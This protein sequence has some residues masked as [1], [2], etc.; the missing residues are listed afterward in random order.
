METPLTGAER[1]A[2]FRARLK[3][4]GLRRVQLV[5]PDYSAPKFQVQ[6]QAALARLAAAPVSEEEQ[7]LVAFAD[8]AW[9]D[10]DRDGY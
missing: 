9:A 4:R 1:A 6:L 7:A 2:R 3:D 10:L 8:S 5:I